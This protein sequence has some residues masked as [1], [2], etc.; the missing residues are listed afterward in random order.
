MYNSILQNGILRNALKVGVIS[1]IFA[2][3]VRVNLVYAGEVSG[4]Y[5]EGSRYG[6][7]KLV[8]SY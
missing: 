7:G 6:K 4:T 8:R 3:M 2:Q 5:I 1:S